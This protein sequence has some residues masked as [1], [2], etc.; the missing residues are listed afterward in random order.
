[1]TEQTKQP[2][3]AI[4]TERLLLRLPKDMRESVGRTA[5]D[6]GQTSNEFVREAIRLHLDNPH[7][8]RKT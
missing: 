1:M 8:P 3:F 5:R 6:V 2:R 4:F 7:K